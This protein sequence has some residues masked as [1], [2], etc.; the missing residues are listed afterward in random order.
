MHE[1][2]GQTSRPARPATPRAAASAAA[3]AAEQLEPRTFFNVTLTPIQVAVGQNVNISRTVS[4]QNEGTIAID[5]TNPARMFAAAVMDDMETGPLDPPVNDNSTFTA[6]ST[7]AGATWTAQLIG[8]G[9][10]GFAVACCDP[11]AAW[12]EFGNLFYA[13]LGTNPI[14]FSRSIEILLS[15]DGGQTFRNVYSFSGRSDQPTV[16][17][18]EGMVWV[19]FETGNRQVAA[20][21]RVEGLGAV[22]EFTDTQVAPRSVGG[23]FGDIAIGPNGEVMV[24]YQLP[25]GSGGKAATLY[26]SIDPDGLGPAEFGRRYEIA[27]TNIV[28]F[29]EIPPQDDRTVDAEVSLAWDRSGGPF[30]GRVYAVYT[31]EAR[32]EQGSDTNILLRFSDDRGVTWSSP[33]Q[34]NDQD[35]G[36]RSQFLSR[37]AIDQTTGNIAVVWH[38]TRVEPGIS[39]GPNNE[40]TLWGTAITPSFGEQGVVV[41]TNV[42]ISAGVS[43]AHRSRARLEYGDYLGLD[44]RNNV[45]H[46]VWADNSNSTGDNPSGG[47]MGSATD[48]ATLDLYTARVTVT[49]TPPAPSPEQ[50]VGPGSALSPAFLGQDTVTKGKL[51]K[52]RVEY[53]SASGVDAGSLGD[54]DL[55]VTGP[56]GYRQFA[57]L[58]RVKVSRRNNTVTGTYQIPAPGGGRFDEADNGLYSILLQGGAVRDLAGNTIATGLLDKFLV[59]VQPPRRPGRPVPAPTPPEPTEPIPAPGEDPVLAPL[60][61]VGAGA[62]PAGDDRDDDDDDLAAIGLA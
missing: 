14:T 52:F 31:D 56:N 50:P 39:R 35:F 2:T 57:D 6:W 43:D 8:T 19:N 58:T 44:F 36:S 9:D 3:A 27:P 11:S 53:E 17:V 1:Q 21:A 47:V 49:A 46:P 60:H 37:S 42:Q 13:Y 33:R 10:D 40:A 51:F 12:D 55:L 41:G 20:G 16:V 18:G 48:L 34:V 29:D 23:R 30:T 28:G 4:N 25:A 54:D 15:T 22:G 7:D 24:S 5:P 45:F 32:D 62:S 61:A 59:S 26:H 38:D